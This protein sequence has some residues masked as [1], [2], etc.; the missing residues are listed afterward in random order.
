MKI[1]GKELFWCADD[2]RHIVVHT[3]HETIVGLVY[4]QGDDSEG[5]W[6]A[7]IDEDLTSFFIAIEP[8]LSG[9]TE[10]ERIN[11]AIWAHFEYRAGNLN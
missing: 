1:Q 6:D 5:L 11:K 8:M 9:A 3:K 2:D 10:L 7:P 4:C